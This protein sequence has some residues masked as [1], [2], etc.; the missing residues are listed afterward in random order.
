MEYNTYN[1][2]I[3][4]HFKF[5]PEA[6]DQAATLSLV[7]DSP[8]QLR[9]QRGKLYVQ[10][11]YA[12][13]AELDEGEP[14]LDESDLAKLERAESHDLPV[15]VLSVILRENN[16]CVINA[17]SG[18]VMNA[19]TE[20]RTFE[21]D[22]RELDDEVIDLFIPETSPADQEAFAATHSGQKIAMAWTV[23]IEKDR[24]GFDQIIERPTVVAL[25][26]SGVYTPVASSLSY[27]SVV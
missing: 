22:V 2:I 12:T 14:E 15:D 3:M 25:D 8:D 26:E 11:T 23:V 27:Y 1:I 9:A 6:N 5:T 17:V 21:D 19:T 18:L 24:H 16:Q 10:A 7:A 4:H 13:H 20:G